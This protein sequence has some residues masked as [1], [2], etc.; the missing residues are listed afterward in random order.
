VTFYRI[1]VYLH[2]LGVLGWFLGLGVEAAALVQLGRAGSLERKREA[3]SVFRDNRVL[4]PISALLVLG[5]GI[6]MA[7]TVWS[8]HPPWVGLGYLTFIV[9]FALGAALTGR[10]IIKLERALAA[11]PPRDVA[12]PLGMLRVSLYARLGLLLGVTFAMVVKPEALG[13]VAGVALGLALGLAA[14]LAAN[15][16][17]GSRSS[18]SSQNAPAHWQQG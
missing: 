17:A 11:E 1:V 8:S 6:Y 10:P 3:L 16:S 9:V 2:V 18:A 14:A 12:A 4:G 13:C 7:Q 5:P 15:R